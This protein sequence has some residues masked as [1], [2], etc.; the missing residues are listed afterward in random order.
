VSAT[1]PGPAKAATLLADGTYQNAN[2]LTRINNGGTVLE[3]LDLPL[4]TFE[5][6]TQALATYGSAGFTLATASQVTALFDAFG[7]V[8]G[9]VPGD[10]YDLGA[11]PNAASFVSHLG[12]TQFGTLSAGHFDA[13][14]GSYFCIG[15]AQN[16]VSNNNITFSSAIVGSTLVRTA[17]VVAPVPLPAALPL[18]ATGL[19]AIG[20]LTWRRKRKAIAA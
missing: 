8:Y 10:V 14:F 7:I 2:D 5:T 3:F 19:G 18:F 13:G 1:T 15:C 16:F 9:F 17:A 6:P 11:V 12:A 4:T 20:L